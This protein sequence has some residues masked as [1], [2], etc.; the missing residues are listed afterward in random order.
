MRDLD[1]LLRA[2][3]QVQELAQQL[4]RQVGAPVRLW[5]DQ[6]R[7]AEAIS[8]EFARTFRPVVLPHV[9]L[10]A[11]LEYPA[12]ALARQWEVSLSQMQNAAR[13]MNEDFAAQFRHFIAA[14]E[15]VTAPMSLAESFELLRQRHRELQEAEGVD[16]PE[17]ADQIA[18][19]V[20]DD[21]R[22]IPPGPL[23]APIV[24]G[25]LLSILL[26]FLSLD[27]SHQSERRIL[28]H[29]RSVEDRIVELLPDATLCEGAFGVEEAVFYVARRPVEIR[30]RPSGRRGRILQRLLGGHRV[31][32]VNVRGKW[33]SV[34]YFDH[35]RNEF[36][37][38]WAL[39]KYFGRL[40][41]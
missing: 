2:L 32:C 6:A 36:A 37:S 17:A 9:E 4:D 10:A 20:E 5:R 8:R 11:G 14:A 29:M 31:Q 25:W 12:A 26:F 1:K 22:H 21:L 15:I 38:G 40:Q 24:F 27:T 34:S 33:I 30:D 3:R 28:E 18:A 13:R 19:A 7:Q 41:E 39:K 35:E 23:T 16:D